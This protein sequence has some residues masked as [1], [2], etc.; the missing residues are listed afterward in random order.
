MAVALNEELEGQRPPDNQATRRKL[1]QHWKKQ[2]QDAQGRL[3][4]LGVTTWAVVADQKC[5]SM[6]SGPKKRELQEYFDRIG[7]D[8]TAIRGKVNPPGPVEHQRTW[9]RKEVVR[10]LNRFVVA[11]GRK[12]TLPFQSFPA[13]V[14]TRRCPVRIPNWP[15]GVRFSSGRWKKSK[16]LAISEVA[17]AGLLF[18]ECPDEC[19]ICG[20]HDLH[21]VGTSES[22]PASTNTK[23][24][25][26]PVQFASGRWKESELL[27]VSEVA[28]AG[29]FFEECSDVC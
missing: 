13:A 20:K 3:S 19:E 9:L 8:L 10:Q 4:Q 24:T 29:L 22:Q 6:I 17:V 18:E 5:Q 2:I 27:A 14:L 1:I 15:S 21:S 26:G 11:H 12:C 28:V 16:L 25:A 23:G 7:L